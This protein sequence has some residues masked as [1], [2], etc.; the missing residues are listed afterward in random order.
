VKKF[1]SKI[2]SGIKK[3]FRLITNKWL[4]KGTTT[5]IVVALV[6]AGYIGI[7][8]VAEQIKIED[9]DFTPEKLYSLSDETK[10]RIK[11]LNTE[12]TIQLINMTDYEYVIEYADKY[13]M[14]SDKIIIEEINDLISRVDLQTKYDIGSTDTLIVV[15]NGDREKTLTVN[16]LISYIS[17]YETVNVT[18]EA[19]T[20]AII[21]VTI[22]DRPK[23]YVLSGKTY[24][25]PE[26]SFGI[27]ANKLMDESN[28]VDL[29]DITT[30]GNVPEDCDCLIITTLAQ[31]LSELERDKILEYI[32]NGGKILMLTSQGLLNIDTPNFDQVLAQYGVNIGYGAIFEQDEDKKLYDTPNMI[33]AET[34]AS[35]MNDLDKILKIFVVSPGKIEFSDETKLEELCVT[36]E[37]LAK[38]SESSFMRT[39]FDQ[40]STSRTDKDSEEGASIIGA[41]VTK[42][43]SEDKDSQLIIYS[44]ETFASTIET[45]IGFMPK[46]YNNEDVILNSISHLTEREDTITIRNTYET[47]TYPVTDQEDI[48]VK[49]IIFSMPAL[50]IM[51]GIAV[52]V[53]RRRRV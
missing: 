43:I 16:D 52:W 49:T 20:N 48:I 26:T 7:N 10:N 15:K 41:Y 13:R 31:D 23:I 5:V 36:Y 3:L 25:Q 24:Y 32:N 9:I 4:L 35:F 39:D 6:I 18:E 14:A 21:E 46:L 53:Y 38:T 51:V 17:S 1:F 50:V 44:D 34:S 30:K 42:E 29:L 27:I 45:T 2:A 19:I 40:S 8:W 12:I 37:V 28:E 11:D 22:E 47:E 33:I